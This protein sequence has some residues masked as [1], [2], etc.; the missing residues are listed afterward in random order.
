VGR[1]IYSASRERA[2]GI[3]TLGFH[4]YLQSKQIDIESM[5]AYNI[6]N[7]I[8]RTISD[9]LKL[10]NLSIGRERGEAPDCAGTGR[11]FSHVMAIAPNATSSIIMGNTSPSCEPFRANVYKQDTL[12]GSHIAY[13]KH[14][15]KLLESRVKDENELS[16]VLSSIKRNDGSVQHLSDDL[17]TAHE[18][19][20]FKCWPEINS[21][22][23][24]R[25][26]AARQKYIDQSQS[27]SLFF[28]PNA[29]KQIVNKV[30]I[31][32]WKAGLKTLYYYR[33][34]KLLVVDKIASTECTYCEG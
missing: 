4:S 3:G 6:N 26:A 32:A 2:V 5:A 33:S 30:H 18:K 11:R 29:D 27:L 8:F 13:N 7:I 21:L 19:K 12:S 16:N 23:L 20:V 14:L 24:I 28:D 10:V 17:L 1:A 9:N 22:A 31:E 34:R 15:K 25:L